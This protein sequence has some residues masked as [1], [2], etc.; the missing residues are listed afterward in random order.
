MIPVAEPQ[1][2]ERDIELVN[3]ALKSG[4]MSDSVPDFSTW[5]ATAVCRAN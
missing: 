3:E 5:Y 2:T 1:V 4:W